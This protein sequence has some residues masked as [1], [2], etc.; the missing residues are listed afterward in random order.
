MKSFIFFSSFDPN[1]SKFLTFSGI[2][3]HFVLIEILNFFNISL[4][5]SINFFRWFPNTLV[6]Q[7]L[8]A[9]SNIDLESSGTILLISKN[10][11]IPMPSQTLHAPWGAL[12]LN[13]LGSISSI[14]NPDTGQAN[15]DE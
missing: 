13:N 6:S 11:S 1:I 7:G 15:L 4:I 2:I 14:V 12:K 10:S 5:V 9:P 8:I 3:F